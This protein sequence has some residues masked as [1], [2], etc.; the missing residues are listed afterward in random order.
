MKNFP[1]RVLGKSNAR[2]KVNA[3]E[4]RGN[5]GGLVKCIDERKQGSGQTPRTGVANWR[6]S[7]KWNAEAGRMG[8]QVDYFERIT[9]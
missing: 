7:I 9:A 5:P 3:I 6:Q 2:R 4:E 1:H 8:G